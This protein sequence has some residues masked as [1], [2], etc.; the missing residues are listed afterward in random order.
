M[1][2]LLTGANGQV[3]WELVRTLACLGE[4]VA[5][6]RQG[7]D[8]AQ[9]DGIRNTLRTIR[10]QV[11]VNAAAY[12]AVDAAEREKSLAFAI[13]GDAPGILAEEARRLDA[14][15]IHYST[16]YVFDGKKS[17]PYREEDPTHPLSVYGQSKQAGEA[18]IAASG[19]RHLIF[20][21]SWV[22][23]RRGRNFFLTILRL[24]REKE[25]LKVVADQIGAPTWSRMIAEATALALAR[26]HGQTGLYHLCASGETS[27]H[28]FAARI[29]ERAHAQG[30]LGKLLPVRPITS[31][32]YPAAAPRPA[33]SRLDCTHL[34]QDFALTLP[35]W[36]TQ[37]ALCLEEMQ[38]SLIEATQKV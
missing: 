38:Q 10:P 3:G 9:P 7:L 34:R 6:D 30:L 35:D 36:E 21:V 14:L 15:L 8:L 32:E 4:V 5:F 28:G 27:W 19:C 23:G 29:I 24:A 11:I 37:L 12:T 1:K 20:R 16:D 2:I 18:A 31:A 26:Y 17:A 25:E 13:N 22:Y 33:N